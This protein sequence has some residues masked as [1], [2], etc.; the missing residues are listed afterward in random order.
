MCIACLHDPFDF[1]DR[2]LRYAAEEKEMSKRKLLEI[3][4]KHLRGT[5][6]DI[7]SVARCND[8][9]NIVERIKQR[10]YQIA[11]EM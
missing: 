9:D 8:G 5:L 1:L 6:A 11:Q 4:A 3:E 2:A 7:G 10:F